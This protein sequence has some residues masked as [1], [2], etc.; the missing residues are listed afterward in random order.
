[1]NLLIHDPVLN[2][3][4]TFLLAVRYVKPTAHFPTYVRVFALLNQ[5]LTYLL[6]CRN[7]LTQL[8]RISALLELEKSFF[9]DGIVRKPVKDCT[10][11]S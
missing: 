3:Q 5:L 10:G 4:L 2:Q 6:A 9:I 1:M 11:F 8:L 7:R